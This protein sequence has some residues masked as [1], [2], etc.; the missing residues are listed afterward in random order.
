MDNIEQQP[1][2]PLYPVYV[3]LNDKP[4]LVV[5]GGT[6]ACE[7]V[8]PLIECGARIT[9]VAPE[10]CDEIR[11]HAAA[12][13]LILEERCY[14]QG[15]ATDYFMT[16]AATSDTAVNTQVYQDAS[17]DGHLVNVVDVPPLCD[18]YVPSIVRKGPL[19]IAISTTGSSPGLAKRLRKWMESELPDE[20]GPLLNELMGVR[21]CL[22]HV[23]PD[24]KKRMKINS[25]IANSD[26]VDAYLAGNPAPLQELIE[27]AF[28][29]Y[30]HQS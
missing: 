8:G 1:E 27:D 19:Q 6:I 23:E 9:L 29:P 2:P 11:A 7:K 28:A 22:K 26:A 30:R 5:G 12:G 25:K 18:F 13:R 17:S 20:Y 16:I 4:C 24:S 10:I 3:K 21:Q 15:E 14:Q